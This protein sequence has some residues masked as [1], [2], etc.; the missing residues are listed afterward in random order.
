MKYMIFDDSVKRLLNDGTRQD[1][2]PC[3]EREKRLARVFYEEPKGKKFNVEFSNEGLYWVL[4][5]NPDL[6]QTP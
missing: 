5:I 3:S 6:R 1:I 2:A 4:P